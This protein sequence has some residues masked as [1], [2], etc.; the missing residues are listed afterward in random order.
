MDPERILLTDGPFTRGMNSHTISP[1]Q[2]VP[3]GFLMDHPAAPR[4][5]RTVSV[6]P[7]RADG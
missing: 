7:Y 4:F 2:T 6:T 3:A 5:H 1:T